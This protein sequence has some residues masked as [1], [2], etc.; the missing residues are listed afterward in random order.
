MT[1]GGHVPGKSVNVSSQTYCPFISH[2][3]IS[4]PSSAFHFILFVYS[5]SRLS[6]SASPC[7][8]L[9]FLSMSLSPTLKLAL[10]SPAQSEVA[11]CF[12]TVTNTVRKEADPG[13]RV[14]FPSQQNEGR[15]RA[16]QA[17]YGFCS[18]RTGA[19]RFYIRHPL[20]QNHVPW[21]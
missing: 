2:P 3:L 15:V 12:F 5:N 6:C 20:K 19:R 4:S 11:L 21:V 7:P 1:L 10:K 13:N 16:E 8:F 17:G 9:S 14:S 18:G